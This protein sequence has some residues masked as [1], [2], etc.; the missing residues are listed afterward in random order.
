MRFCGSNVPNLNKAFFSDSHP[1]LGV[2]PLLATSPWGNPNYLLVKVLVAV[3]K[4]KSP[5]LAGDMRIAM[6]HAV[7]L[8][9]GSLWGHP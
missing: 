6:A 7:H 1:R 4:R 3:L 5:G 8:K 9:M 2:S